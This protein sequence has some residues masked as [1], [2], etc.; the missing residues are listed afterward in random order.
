MH[1]SLLAPL[2]SQQPLRLISSSRLLSAR[3]QGSLSIATGIK[4]GPGCRGCRYGT[5]QDTSFVPRNE[6]ARSLC[7]FKPQNSLPPLPKAIDL[8]GLHF[9]HS[10]VQW[11]CRVTKHLTAH[12]RF[13]TSVLSSFGFSWLTGAGLLLPAEA[14]PLTMRASTKHAR[15][16]TAGSWLPTVGTLGRCKILFLCWDRHA[17]CH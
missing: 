5:H 2:S 8:P 15:V 14:S 7:N 6:E 4:N 12:L 9:L 17:L 1:V 16:L 3:P 10:A 11:L 13:A